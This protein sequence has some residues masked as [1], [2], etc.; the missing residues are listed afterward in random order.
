M[1]ASGRKPV[2]LIKHASDLSRDEQ[3]AID[4]PQKSKYANAASLSMAAIVR[5]KIQVNRRIMGENNP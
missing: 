5:R 2:K 4:V 3:A 1:S